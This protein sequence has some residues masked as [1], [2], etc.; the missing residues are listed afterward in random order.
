MTKVDEQMIEGPW[1]THGWLLFILGLLVTVMIAC[2]FLVVYSIKTADDMVVKDYYER[3]SDINTLLEQMEK[4]KQL[5]LSATL[6][7]ADQTIRL[8]LHPANA[9]ALPIVL[10][11][12]NAR[13]K[14]ND[15]EV[16]LQPIEGGSYSASL[17][18]KM[19]PGSYY[20]D[21][22]SQEENPWRMKASVSLP[23]TELHIAP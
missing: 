20:V 18:E 4:A 15:L 14:D 8:Q 22:A 21:I 17:S 19:A 12:S 1:Y 9:V 11:L 16:V 3:G 13:D 2:A 5:E 7:F 10:Q 6:Y 23:G